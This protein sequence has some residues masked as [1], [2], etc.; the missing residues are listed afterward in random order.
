MLAAGRPGQAVWWV[1]RK[2][3]DEA[4]R[5]RIHFLEAARDLE[6]IVPLAALARDPGFAAATRLARA[7]AARP[8][9]TLYL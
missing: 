3:C 5:Q 6:P 1:L 8:R 2:F 4:T 7:A 9:H